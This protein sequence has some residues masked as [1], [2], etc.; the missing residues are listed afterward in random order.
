MFNRLL[1]EGDIPLHPIA[2]GTCDTIM[3][4]QAAGDEEERSFLDVARHLEDTHEILKVYMNTDSRPSSRQVWDSDTASGPSH[5][6][7]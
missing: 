6:P 5:L 3:A 7:T 2:K 1:F 4:S